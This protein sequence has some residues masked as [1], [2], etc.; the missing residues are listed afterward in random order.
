MRLLWLEENSVFSLVEHVGRDIPPYAILSHTWGADHEEVTFKDLTEDTGKSKAGYRK[1]TFCGEQAA[2]DGLHFFWVDT[3][4]IDKSSSAELTEAINSMFQWYH[5]ADKCYVYLSDVS[6]SSLARDNLSLQ[7]S[8]WFTRGWT[9]QELVAPTSVEFFSLEGE[10]IGDKSSMAQEIHNITG[11]SIQ[12]LRGDCL[13]DFSV[14]ERMSWAD[15]RETKREEDAAYALLGLFDTH[16]PLI[17]GEGREKAFDR[18]RREIKESSR[19]ELPILSQSLA[20]DAAETMAEQ[21]R[22]KYQILFSL[23]GVPVGR[24]ASRPQDTDALER[25]LLPQKRNKRRLVLVMHGL[26]GVGK[27]QL[28]ADFAR[29]HQHSFS[30]V[31]WLDGS[32]ESSL[33]Q[34]LARFA[35]R[36]PA[37]QTPETSRM[38]AAGQCGDVDAVVRDVLDWLSTPNNSNWLVVI[39]N[40]DQ[41]YRQ[42][43]EDAEAYDV[44]EYVPVADRGSVLITTR[45]PHLGQ[46]GERWE[47]KKVDQEQARAIFKTWY[48][49]GIGKHLRVWLQR[50]RVI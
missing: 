18:L 24:F 41:D 19:H 36:I 12:A 25:A 5:N 17:Y 48:G 2:K 49:R 3:C 23:K 35:S 45:L 26:G 37:G 47:V 33:K 43:K 10:W 32:S 31:L 8:R 44:E 4:C 46:L 27:T 13:S 40:V 39:D 14:D 20:I 22:R 15:K 16:M 30:S 29:R 38:Y 9:L 1:L 11:I 6:I 28:A 34:S 50:L 42:R 21:E 7:K